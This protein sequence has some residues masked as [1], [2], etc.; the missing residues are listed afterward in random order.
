MTLICV[1]RG[2]ADSLLEQGELDRGLTCV[3]SFNYNIVDKI[4]IPFDNLALRVILNGDGSQDKRI[5]GSFAEVIKAK[6]DD[7]KAWNR[8]KRLYQWII[9]PRMV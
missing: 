6:S 9:V 8:L 3:E 2:V 1:L 5:L 4:C 7:E